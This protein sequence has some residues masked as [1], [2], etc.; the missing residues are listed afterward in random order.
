MLSGPLATNESPDDVSGPPFSVMYSKVAGKP[1][2]SADTDDAAPH[3]YDRDWETKVIKYI[4]QTFTM[5]TSIKL[6][7]FQM[8]MEKAQEFQ[9][10]DLTLTM[11]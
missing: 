5:K 2:W 6:M 9:I 1:Y 3:P 8:I 7:V 10:L 4:T 11:V